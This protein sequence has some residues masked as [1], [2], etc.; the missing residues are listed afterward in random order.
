MC[1]DKLYDKI[2]RNS[3]EAERQ[4]LSMATNM[5]S[6]KKCNKSPLTDEAFKEQLERV[7]RDNVLDTDI[8]IT[9]DTVIGA[10]KE[11]LGKYSEEENLAYRL[12]W[13]MQDYYKAGK[14]DEEREHRVKCYRLFWD[15]LEDTEFFNRLESHKEELTK[16]QEKCKKFV[17]EQK[18]QRSADNVSIEEHIKGFKALCDD[19]S[20]LSID[21]GKQKPAEWSEEDEAM[22]DNILR[23]LSCFIGNVE[24][25]SNPSLSTSYPLYKREMDWLKSL[26]PSWK[27]SE[28]QMEA[29]E[30]AS[31][32]EYLSAKQFDILVSLYEQLKKL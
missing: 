15:A 5:I 23:V 14:D 1:T 12:N 20:K 22:R 30:R 17:E 8:R 31:T 25:E 21:S 18:E 6:S 3:R 28:E 9:G 24:C 2:I 16:L 10:K 13:L 29:L 27:P 4:Y 11:E 19:L 26:R 32:N 7:L